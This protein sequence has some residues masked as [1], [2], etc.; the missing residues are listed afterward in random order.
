VGIVRQQLRRLKEIQMALFRRNAAQQSHPQGT[1][2]W[3]A[4]A[5]AAVRDAVV[6]HAHAILVYRGPNRLRREF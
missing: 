2:I 6:N 5:E 4:R 1:S 3:R